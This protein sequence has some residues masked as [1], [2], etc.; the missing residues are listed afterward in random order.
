[1][2]KNGSPY[3]KLYAG[4]HK[5]KCPHATWQEEP[6]QI[7]KFFGSVSPRKRGN[8]RD[9]NERSSQKKTFYFV[10]GS[11]LLKIKP[12][13]WRCCVGVGPV[14][15]KLRILQIK[16]Q[17]FCCKRYTFLNTGETLL[18]ASSNTHHNVSINLHL[19]HAI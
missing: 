5:K 9:I 12:G 19:G 18:L 11:L 16:Y 6:P 2:A 4:K 3:K 1:M 10:F 15:E 17:T 13:G 14:P 7:V 8:R